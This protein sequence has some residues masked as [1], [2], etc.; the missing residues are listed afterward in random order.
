MIE[1]FSNDEILGPSECESVLFRVL[2]LRYPKLFLPCSLGLC[3]VM[4]CYV[5]LC[6]VM[7]CYVML[8]HV[9]V[10]ST[11]NLSPILETK[12]RCPPFPSKAHLVKALPSTA[13]LDDAN[14]QALHKRGDLSDQLLE[15]G[16]QKVADRRSMRPRPFTPCQDLR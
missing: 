14:S 6:H 1:N 16:M 7:S 12:S 3:H 9:F 15:V 5:M 4:S 11:S 8:C 2:P 10:R 13:I